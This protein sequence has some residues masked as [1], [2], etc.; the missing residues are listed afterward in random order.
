MLK[1][2]VLVKN[3][4]FKLEEFFKKLQ[5]H[6]EIYEGDDTIEILTE[7]LDFEAFKGQMLKLKGIDR[8]IKKEDVYAKIMTHE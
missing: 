4:N 8:E 1:S 6:P 5:D 7:F 2:S 3:P